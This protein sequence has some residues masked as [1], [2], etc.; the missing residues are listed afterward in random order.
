MPFLDPE[1]GQI[2]AEIIRSI[3]HIT[4]NYDQPLTIDELARIGAR[5]RGAFSK[6]FRQYTGKSIK[7][8]ITELRIKEAMHMIDTSN[9]PIHSIA[10]K[11]GYKDFST[12][13]R[14]FVQI[15]GVSPAKYK[16]SAG[17]AEQLPHLQVAKDDCL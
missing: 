16:E 1:A 8:Y 15:A 9:I 10:E 2:E 7:A 6:A 17:Y 4:A 11:V 3:Q 5:S 13:Y 12:F 14:N